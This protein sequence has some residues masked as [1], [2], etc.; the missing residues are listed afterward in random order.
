MCSYW[1]HLA[2][3]RSVCICII[4]AST[5]RHFSFTESAST[6]DSSCA[7]HF[8]S[9]IW[10]TCDHIRASVPTIRYKRK[11]HT[12]GHFALWTSFSIRSKFLLIVWAFTCPQVF[13]IT[14]WTV[15]QTVLT[16]T[17]NS[18]G[19]RQILTPTKSI[20]LNRLTTNLAQ[21]ITSMRGPPIPNLVE[22]HQLGASG[23][24]GWNI[25]KNIFICT[26]FLWSA[27]RSDP[28]MDFYAR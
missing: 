8:S 11:L 7:W 28:L 19:D 18:Y 22:I 17:F 24:N 12:M 21:L 4:S 23:K 2:A 14:V 27:Y 1:H 25:T 6:K 3:S 26:F 10:I 20:P 13:I 16:A 9:S 5:S 15:V